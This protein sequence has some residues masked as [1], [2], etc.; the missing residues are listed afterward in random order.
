MKSWIRQIAIDLAI[1]FF[2]IYGIVYN[3]PWAE[4]VGVFFFILF[5][6]LTFIS[7]LVIHIGIKVPDAVENNSRAKLKP[8]FKKRDTK[9]YKAYH[10]ITDLLWIGFFVAYDHM[11]LATTYTIMCLYWRA[12]NSIITDHLYPKE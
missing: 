11:L 9:F 4:R 3:H 6:V 1:A 8:L 10:L 2:L 12:A 7:V 5:S